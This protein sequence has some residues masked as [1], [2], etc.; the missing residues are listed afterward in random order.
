LA[1]LGGTVVWPTR[2]TAIVGLQPGICAPAVRLA[3]GSVF[4]DCGSGSPRPRDAGAQRLGADAV[5]GERHHRVVLQVAALVKTLRLSGVATLFPG[6]P[7]HRQCQ[8]GTISIHWEGWGPQFAL[9]ADHNSV[10]IQSSP[11]RTA[12]CGP[13]PPPLQASRCQRPDRSSYCLSGLKTLRS[14]ASPPTHAL[15]PRRYPAIWRGETG[16]RAGTNLRHRCAES[17]FSGR[18]DIKTEQPVCAGA[19]PTQGTMPFRPRRWR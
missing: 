3:E 1:A 16:G 9:S 10:V 12:F 6:M 15:A 18:S 5:V 13:A 7:M 14:S 8:H 17:P 4:L 2:G 19:A 11:D